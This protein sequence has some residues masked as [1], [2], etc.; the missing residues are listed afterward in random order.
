MIDYSAF[1]LE[2]I[3]LEQLKA[4]EEILNDWESNPYYID[5]KVVSDF[6]NYIQKSTGVAIIGDYDVDGICSTYIMGKS[7]QKVCPGKKIFLRIPKR[8]SEGYGINQIIAEEIK[9]KLPVGS[10]VI[11]VDN[12][13]KAKEVLEDLEKSGYKVLM[14]DH[15]GIKE[16]EPLPNVT[17]ALNPSVP[18]LSEAFDFKKWCGA[19]VAFKL[20]EQVIPKDLVKELEVF[21]GLATVADCMELTGGNWGLVRKSIRLFREKKA[22]QSLTNMMIMM[23]QNPLFTTEHSFGYYLGPC[24]NAAG[25]LLDNG[26]SLVLKYLFSPTEEKLQQLIELNNQRKK[27]RDEEYVLVKEAIEKS[28]QTNACPIWVNVPN[29]HEGI[30][31]IL[32]GKVTEEYKVPAIVTTNSEK[33]FNILKGSARTYGDFNIF[34]YLNNMSELFEKMGGHPGAAGL[35][36]LKENFENGK[37]YQIAKEKIQISAM[38]PIELYLHSMKIIPEIFHILSKY[39]PFGEGNPEPRFVLDIDLNVEKGF[40]HLGKEK[41]HLVFDNQKYKI[42][43]WYHKPN[44]LS[45]KSHFRSYGNILETNYKGLSTPT[46]DVVEIEDIYDDKEKADNLEILHEK[47]NIKE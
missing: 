27:L 14:T 13:I 38:T 9:A 47:E 33:D 17:M 28:G 15:H 41:E 21:A 29:L 4:T 36:I 10:V 6:W 26:G 30:I 18:E 22:P 12:G 16:G 45:N 3:L 19:G 5:G 44:E 2:N 7:I 32:A 35:S 43:H 39:R 25:R 37:K 42:T 40:A 8:F 1:E 23:N 11:T 20:C 24:F 46:F 34:A 31:G